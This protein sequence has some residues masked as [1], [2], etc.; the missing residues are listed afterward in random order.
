MKFQMVHNNFNV[1]DLAKSLKFYAD[2]FD[3]HEVRRIAPADGSFIIVYLEDGS[4]M[5]QLELTWLR[6]RKEPYNLGDNEF[7]LAFV[8]DDY[9]AAHARHQK[10]GCICYENP[11]MG[12][13]FVEDPDGYWLEV[14][15]AKQ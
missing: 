14:I 8:T 11:D 1:L 13:Y 12:I 6:E 2:A 15:P 4:S 7:H 10:M 3:M 5:H 9:N